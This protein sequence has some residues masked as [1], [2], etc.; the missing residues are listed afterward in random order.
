VC[1]MFTTRVRLTPSLSTCSSGR[2]SKNCKRWRNAVLMWRIS[3]IKFS[4]WRSLSSRWL[5]PSTT[6]SNAS[7]ETS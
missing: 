3:K 5:S 1:W 7:R 6:S 2:S 4:I